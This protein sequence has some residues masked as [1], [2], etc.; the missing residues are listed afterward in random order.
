MPPTIHLILRS[1]R[2]ARLE[3]RTVIMQPMHVDSSEASY[4]GMSS[5]KFRYRPASATRTAPFG[6]GARRKGS[7]AT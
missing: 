4:Y 7:A 1:A 6:R 3:G 5:P 2:R